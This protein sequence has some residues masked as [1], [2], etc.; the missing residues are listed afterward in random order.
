MATAASLL[1]STVGKKVVM[2][3][4]GVILVGFII[5]H[6][7]GNLLVFAGP[8]ELNAYSHLLKSNLEVLW[9]ARV[10]LLVS[11]VLHVWSAL[12]VTRASWAARPVGY[13]KNEPQVTTLAA[14]TMR[15]GG[16]LLL[17]FIV[18]H[19]LHFTVGAIPTLPI[20]ETDVYSNVIA[21]FSTPWVAAIY[22]VAM[23]ALAGHLY[24]GAWAAFRTLGLSR[25]SPTPTQRSVAVL[26]AVGVWAGFTAIVVA[27]V[28]GAVR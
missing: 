8:D 25:P 26:V 11:A 23:V 9:G 24:H 18:F 14:R 22:L 10:V 3:V 7:A 27:I 12:G 16:V 13:G 19:L 20:S 21:G 17:A 2:A 28:A 6:V 5:T 15:V 1:Q 4:T